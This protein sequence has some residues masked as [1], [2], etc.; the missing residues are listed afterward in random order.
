ME[1]LQLESNIQRNVEQL[2]T[3]EIN[4]PINNFELI[5]E[6]KSQGELSQSLVRGDAL[7]YPNHLETVK[8]TRLLEVIP[9]KQMSRE[10]SA[11]GVSF[12]R[13]LGHRP[14]RVGLKHT[15]SVALKSF[16][17]PLTAVREI[18]GYGVLSKLGIETYRPIGI[19][20][21]PKSDKF[22]VVTEKRKGLVSLDQDEWILGRRV[23]SEQSAEIA[24]RNTRTVKEIAC[25]MAKLHGN[26]IFVP[27]GQIKNFAVTEYGKI[28]AIDLENIQIVDLLNHDSAG[29]AWNDFEKLVRS[30]MID[31]SSDY[32]DKIFGVG[33][34]SGM[35]NI[36]LRRCFEELILEPYINQLTE[37]SIN[38][39]VH[40]DQAN[41]LAENLLNNYF[42]MDKEWPS[43]LK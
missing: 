41:L 11:H 32:E 24:S 40:S 42:I 28:G 3:Y 15:A 35:T 33:M 26:G 18:T 37:L 27:D 9:G 43:C 16:G 25:L 31:S 22:I 30:L 29:L 12:G 5:D 14:G 1:D 34:L 38:G 6:T 23:Y 4:F 8:K 20:P 10:R 2:S 7:I 36:D 13:F 39:Q 21:E 17:D 19:F